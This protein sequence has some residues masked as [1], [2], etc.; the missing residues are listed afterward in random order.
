M[1]L[2][3]FRY[4]HGFLATL[5]A[6]YNVNHAHTIATM[7]AVDMRYATSKLIKRMPLL[8]AQPYGCVMTG[9]WDDHCGMW[10]PEE[11][12][13]LAAL[14]CA[15]SSICMA[16]FLL[17]GSPSSRRSRSVLQTRRAESLLPTFFW[18]RSPHF[19]AAQMH[20]HNRA[21]HGHSSSSSTTVP[22]TTRPHHGE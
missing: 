12:A 4:E 10:G 9:I 13:P 11:G 20:S 21:H 2:T 15:F 22:A 6:T 18:F 7:P 17:V 14:H 3:A 19:T 1:L 5:S 8:Q 16:L